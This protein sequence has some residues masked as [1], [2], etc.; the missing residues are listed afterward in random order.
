MFLNDAVDADWDRLHRKERPIPS[1]RLGRSNVYVGA[2]LLLGVGWAS[3]LAIGHQVAFH[4]MG[5]VVA[6]VIYDLVHKRLPF[7][8]VL[9]ALCRWLLY[10][11]AAGAATNGVTQP[12]QLGALAIA[13]YV[14]G[15][16]LVAR[17]E[18]DG[19]WA[20]G[21]ALLLLLCPIAL[22]L[23][24]RRNAV[25]PQIIIAAGIAFLVWTVWCIQLAVRPRP[26]DLP[27]C[28]AGL[29]AGIPLADAVAAASGSW[30]LATTFGGLFLFALL[31]QRFAPAT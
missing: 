6:V 18:S 19:Q 13:G 5:L 23:L 2:A 22:A 4:G 20:P 11:T 21:R 12:A 7:A 15:L 26:R 3:L 27:G 8:P 31:W 29:L 28:V 25:Q 24:A 16:S 30:L 10:I 14:V 9:M 1:G 17:R